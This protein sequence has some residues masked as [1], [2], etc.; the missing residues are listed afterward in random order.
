MSKI[1]RRS[2]VRLAGTGIASSTLVSQSQAAGTLPLTVEQA[3]E[4]TAKV[5]QP[6]ASSFRI[7]PPAGSKS[8]ILAPNYNSTLGSAKL[9]SYRFRNHVYDLSLS[10]SGFEVIKD[11]HSLGVKRNGETITLPCC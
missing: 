4:I 6:F 1:S 5:T 2:F 7:V 8:A 3:S 11:G 9:T 10:N